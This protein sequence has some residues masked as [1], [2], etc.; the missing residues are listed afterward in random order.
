MLN[1]TV[2][3]YGKTITGANVAI[4]ATT[5][6]AATQALTL[7]GNAAAGETVSIGGLIYVWTSTSSQY[8]GQ[9]PFFVKIGADAATS[10]VNLTAAINGTAS[11]GSLFSNN[12]N[13]N[14]YVTAVATSSTVMTV[15]ATA[16]G[17]DGNGVATTETMASASWGAATTTGGISAALQVTATGSVGPTPVIGIQETRTYQN[18]L[19]AA[20]TTIAAGSLAVSIGFS[21]D[22]VGAVGGNAISGATTT[23]YSDASKPGNTLPAIVVTRS[24]GTYSIVVA[25]AS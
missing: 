19:T 6:T 17:A 8:T 9:T 14:P 23:S 12:T 16:S 18:A 5:P 20:T 4:G 24:A 13:P 21:S 11:K 22:F 7:S 3:C 1:P 15:T 25:G 2:P 10:I